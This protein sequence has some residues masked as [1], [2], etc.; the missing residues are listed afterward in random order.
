MWYF[1]IRDV[2]DVVFLFV[3]QDVELYVPVYGKYECFIMQM[4]CV[5]VVC[6]V[7]VMSFHLFLHLCLFSESACIN[8]SVYYIK[9]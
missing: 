2:I 1:C 3:L 6:N 4:L 5:N 7:I 9:L 8:C